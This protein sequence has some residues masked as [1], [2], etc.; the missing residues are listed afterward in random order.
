MKALI[1]TWEGY[2]DHEVIYPYYRCREETP[3][4]S[5]MA[6]KEV[7][8]GIMGTKM[9]A[10][11]NVSDLS[12]RYDEIFNKYDFLIL[13]GGVKALEK[14]RQDK[15]ILRFVHEWDAAGKIIAS[16][17]HGA[18]L[19]ISAKVVKGREIS[20]YYSLEDDITNAGAVYSREPVVM[21]D[22][23]ISSP[24]YNWMG[25]W[26]KEAIDAYSRKERL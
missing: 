22:N 20:G 5:I 18:Q 25:E 4:V 11:L 3:N 10:D 24:H 13:P 16:T 15:K 8:F 6:N 12:V 26:M 14:L 7:I 17:C 2:Q 23:I 1:I 9:N 21:S 19:L